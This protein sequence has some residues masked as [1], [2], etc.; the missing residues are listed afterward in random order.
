M[1]LD[2]PNWVTVEQQSIETEV[3]ASDVEK[4]ENWLEK[5]FDNF[6][7]ISDVMKTKLEQKCNLVNSKQKRIF[8]LENVL[9]TSVTIASERE[10]EYHKLILI[11]KDLDVKVSLFL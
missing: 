6:K 3:N 10:N 1:E 7:T 2:L 5:L 9:K 4:C 11:K 8:E